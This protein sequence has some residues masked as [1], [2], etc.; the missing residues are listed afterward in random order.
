ME[1]DMPDTLI[2]LCTPLHQELLSLDICHEGLVSTDRFTRDT[3]QL[4][5]S[6]FPPMGGT[7]R[8]TQ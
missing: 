8:K 4:A 5:S 3:L 1:R 7:K 6:W 2:N